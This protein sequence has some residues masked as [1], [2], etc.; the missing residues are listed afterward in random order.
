MRPHVT[1]WKSLS[2]G[3]HYHRNEK[4]QKVK[5]RRKTKVDES[6]DNVAVAMCEGEGETDNYKGR[7][8]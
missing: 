7:L 2:I 4:L 1:H 6:Y 5:G 8:F 3:G